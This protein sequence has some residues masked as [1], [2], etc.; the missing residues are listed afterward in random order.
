MT[1][2]TRTRNIRDH[3]PI[4]CQLNYGHSPDGRDRTSGCPRIRR[5]L[6]QLSYIRIALRVGIEPT[7]PLRSHRFSRPG[8]FHICQ[9]SKY[10][11]LNSF[12]KLRIAHFE[13]RIRANEV[14]E[15]RGEQ[16][17]RTLT[18]VTRLLTAFQAVSLP[19]RINSP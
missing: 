18:P 10:S 17:T 13:L 16:G 1:D 14:S 7:L 8:Q 5:V 15:F 4:F 9:R 19:V 12:S 11:F 3:N 2:E 6:S